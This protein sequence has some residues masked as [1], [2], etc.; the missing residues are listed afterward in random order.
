MAGARDQCVFQPWNLYP[1][2]QQK[3]K[4]IPAQ[5]AVEM[6][7]PIGDR[8]NISMCMKE[9]IFIQ[10]HHHA[11]QQSRSYNANKILH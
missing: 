10:R 8:K 3:H 5:H 2:K 6:A 7:T 9:K 4:W 1:A 11:I